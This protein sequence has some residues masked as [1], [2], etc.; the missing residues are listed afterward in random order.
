M[1]FLFFL[2][3]YFRYRL[4]AKDEYSL[5]SPFMFDFFV[6][7]LKKPCRAKD[8]C[9]DSKLEAIAPQSRSKRKFLFK[10]FQYFNSQAIEVVYIRNEDFSL[11]CVERF[12]SYSSNTAIVIEGIYKNKAKN[13]LWKSLLV[14]GDMKL[15]CDFFSFGIVFLTDKPLKKQNY[16]L[17]KK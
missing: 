11:D 4:R 13:D 1:D 6:K 16:I 7:G 14:N 5:H 2:R 12:S 17:C 9:F 3:S 15:C 8:I 10:A